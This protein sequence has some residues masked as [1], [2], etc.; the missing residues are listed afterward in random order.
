[1]V[2][3]IDHF[4]FHHHHY[5]NYYHLHNNIMVDN[6]SYKTLPL[7]ETIYHRIFFID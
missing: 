6:H 5:H 2:I 4:R 3:Q 1:M 7:N